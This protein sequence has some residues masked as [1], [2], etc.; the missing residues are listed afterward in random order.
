MTA[1]TG[2]RVDT[3]LAGALWLVAGAGVG[4][5]I[6]V[7]GLATVPTA[8]VVASLLPTVGARWAVAGLVAVGAGV[9]ALAGLVGASTSSTVS[10]SGTD[11]GDT[12]CQ[13]VTSPY[14]AEPWYVAAVVLAVLAV[15]LVVVAARSGRRLPPAHLAFLALSGAGVLPLVVA[16]LNRDG[17]GDV[18]TEWSGTQCAAS[19]EEWSPWPWLAVGVVLVA[20]GVVLTTLAVRHRARPRPPSAAA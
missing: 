3:W 4:L 18:C 14:D 8:I 1:A 7:L 6:S 16:W 20:A 5:G 15:V 17:P 2:A 13:T 9:T 19:T 12:T 10:C 11:A